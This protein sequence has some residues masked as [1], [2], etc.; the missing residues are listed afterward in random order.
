LSKAHLFNSHLCNQL[1]ALAF[2]AQRA[3][4]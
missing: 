3:A 1:L 2:G 4:R